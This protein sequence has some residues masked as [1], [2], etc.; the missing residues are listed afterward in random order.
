MNLVTE[1]LG[2][3]PKRGC[4]PFKNNSLRRFQSFCQQ[5]SPLSKHQIWSSS[6]SP[7]PSANSKQKSVATAK[8]RRNYKALKIGMSSLKQRETARIPPELLWCVSM[9]PWQAKISEQR[10][11][12]ARVLSLLHHIITFWGFFS[13]EINTEK[14]DLIWKLWIFSNGILH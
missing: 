10:C 8:F 9:K 11:T 5:Y 14:F 6:R 13:S 7:F 4:E 1:G 2:L 12:N 3:Q